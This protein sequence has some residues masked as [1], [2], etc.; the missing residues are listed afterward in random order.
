MRKGERERGKNNITMHRSFA[1]FLACVKWER[2]E[3]NEEEEGCRGQ[4]IKQ[5]LR[6]SSCQPS[7]FAHTVESRSGTRRKRESKPYFPSKTHAFVD[8][9]TC[10]REKKIP[11]SPSCVLEEIER[12]L[13]LVYDFTNGE[14]IVKVERSLFFVFSP[15]RGFCCPGSFQASFLS[16]SLSYCH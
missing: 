15:L 16:L 3:S 1:I 12:G 10:E 8:R 11:F 7:L 14:E 4:I 5:L 2:R 9:N 13:L 6:S